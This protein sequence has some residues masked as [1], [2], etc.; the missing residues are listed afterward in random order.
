MP[1]R[2]HEHGRRATGGGVIPQPDRRVEIVLMKGTDAP[3]PIGKVCQPRLDRWGPAPAAGEHLPR[4]GRG[5]PMQHL[6][7][8]AD[9]AR[10]GRLTWADPVS[11]EPPRPAVH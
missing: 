6:T 3:R 11:R 9:S 2:K 5:R 4:T 1:I 8:P 10:K 7:A